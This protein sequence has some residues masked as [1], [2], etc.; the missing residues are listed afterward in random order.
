MTKH[1]PIII[2]KTPDHEIYMICGYKRTGKDTFVNYVTSEVN[3]DT[4]QYSIYA[5]K[6]YI[7]DFYQK[8]GFYHIEKQNT[9]QKEVFDFSG[10][11]RM[12]FADSL[13]QEVRKIHNIPSSFDENLY[14]ETPLFDGKSFR[15]LCIEIANQRRLCDHNYWSRKAYVDRPKDVKKLLVS[16]FRFFDELLYMCS[17][18]NLIKTF[19]IFRSEVPIPEPLLEVQDPEHSLD[20]FRT[21]YLILAKDKSD[22][23][24]KKAKEVFPYLYNNY[25][26]VCDI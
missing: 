24:F 1:K 23:E 11:S 16:D 13:K 6:K 4:P 3:K 10:G 19:R 12:A 14:K 25:T 17:T 8:D 21:D 7:D 22:D 26:R 15:D 18:G 20:N 5:E 9:T 2:K